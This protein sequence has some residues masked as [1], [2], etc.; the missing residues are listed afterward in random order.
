MRNVF[1]L[2]ALIGAAGIALGVLT[3]IRGAHGPTGPLGFTFE[4]YG[5]P[6]SVIGGLVLLI[7]SLYL[8][9]AWQGRD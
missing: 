5:G 7:A 9:R 6:G 8:R 2:L 3:A 4:N 1:A